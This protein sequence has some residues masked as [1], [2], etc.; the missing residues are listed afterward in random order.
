[1]VLTL[2]LSIIIPT[3]MRSDVLWKTIS[4]LSQQLLPKDE[5][6]LIDQ[7]NPK[8][9][10]P[11]EFENSSW[12]KIYA[13][14]KPSLTRARN[15]GIQKAKNDQIVFLDDDIIPDGQLLEQF[16]S[17]AVKW[18]GKVITGIVDQA[19]KDLSV[20]SPGTVDLNSGEIKTNFCQGFNGETAFFPGGLFLIPNGI[21]PPYPYFNPA[22]R[23]ACQGEEIDFAFRLKK[24]GINFFSSEAIK[25]FHLK[26]L[27]GGCRAP[28]FKEKFFF[29][30]IFNQAL[31]FGRHG[32]LLSMGTFLRR[33]KGFIEFHTRINRV[34]IS[35]VTIGGKY[36]HSR[37]KVFVALWLLSQGLIQGILMRF[38]K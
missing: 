7:N 13:Q 25:I 8:L 38:K 20:P 33:I 26:V 22:F 9:V 2:N 11:I 18:P 19:D 36:S 12:L 14:R 32:M 34:N 31:F 5:L 16:R 3:Y 29:D 1:M 30:H 28:S 6:I 24:L 10:V 15:L 35:D 21:L 23:G 4:D 37:K 27:E 17:A